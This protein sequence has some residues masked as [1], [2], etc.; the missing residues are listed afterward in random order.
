[1]I[2]L[3]KQ[4]NELII[5][6]PKNQR[7]KE[8]QQTLLMLVSNQV[9]KITQVKEIVAHDAVKLTLVLTPEQEQIAEALLTAVQ[10]RMQHI[11]AEQLKGAKP[12]LAAAPTVAPK[13]GLSL[14]PVITPQ[15]LAISA[16]K[17]ETTPPQSQAASPKATSVDEKEKRSEGWTR[18]HGRFASANGGGGRRSDAAFFT[19]RG[20][21]VAPH[22]RASAEGLV[23]E[24]KGDPSSHTVTPPGIPTVDDGIRTAKSTPIRTLPSSPT[25]ATTERAEMPRQMQA[26]SIPSLPPLPSPPSP[27]SSPTPGSGRGTPLAP[28]SPPS[29]PTS[30]SGRGTPFL[31]ARQ[32]GTPPSPPPKPSSSPTSPPQSMNNGKQ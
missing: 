20:M 14:P 27:A 17:R 28:A 5:D 23:R 19:K 7:S 12:V 24:R 11:H 29:S 6:I 15:P 32:R 31:M 3:E 1:V 16:L 21:D 8:L 30:S 4:G 22:N 13:Q 10:Q 25:R 26:A 18:T 9:G 2:G